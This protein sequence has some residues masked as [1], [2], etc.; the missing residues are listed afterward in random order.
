[1]KRRSSHALIA[2]LTLTLAAGLIGCDGNDNDGGELSAETSEAIAKTF[3]DAFT[4]ISLAIAD[5]QN[6]KDEGHPKATSP[7]GDCPQGGTYSVTGSSEFGETS[8][9]LTADV[10]LDNCNG[11]DGSVSIDGSGSFTQSNLDLDLIFD[12]SLAGENC[13]LS[14]DRFRETLSSDFNSG[15]STLTLDG[16]Y[17]GACAGDGFT[18]SF[19]EVELS[20][21]S[22]GSAEIV[23][24]SCRLN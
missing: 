5:L 17:T 10:D 2:A 24:N 3:S 1:M 16:R 7:A 11:I 8:F 9:S 6:A 20:T 4:G 12:G 23:R 21:A 19:N 15:A 18:C 22:V 13:S 14:F